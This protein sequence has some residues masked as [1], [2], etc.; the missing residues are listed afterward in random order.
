MVLDSR[1]SFVALTDH[2]TMDGF[3][4]FS[5]LKEYGVEVIKGVELTV[6][7]KRHRFHVIVLE[8]VVLPG[9]Y[10][11]LEILQQQR[12]TRI[13]RIINILEDSGISLVRLDYGK[14]KIPTKRDICTAA[15]IEPTNR[16]VFEKLSI[17]NEKTFGRYYFDN[18]PADLKIEGIH[19]EEILP[20]VKG[21]FILAHPGKSIRLP[22]KEQIIYDIIKRFPFSGIEVVTRKHTL[23]NQLFCAQIASDMDLVAVTSNDAHCE[24]HLHINCTPIQQLET[25]RRGALS[26]KSISLRSGDTELC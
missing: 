21:I 15:V 10:N 4:E 16:P 9:F 1:L 5:I 8:P 23:N 20:L 14:R 12:R 13:D 7:F 17:I 3:D 18:G 6:V 22:E 19:A 26:T 24:E 25:L 11:C 2:D